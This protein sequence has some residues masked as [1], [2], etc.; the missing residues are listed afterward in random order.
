M[1]YGIWEYDSN[2]GLIGRPE[3]LPEIYVSKQRIWETENLEVG[4]VW[5][6]P[7][8]FAKS[9][10]FT[11]AIATDFNKAFYFAMNDI[12]GQRPES[13]HMPFDLDAR[14]LSHQLQILNNI[15]PGPNE[16]ILA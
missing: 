14:T 10:W 16:E 12:E 9:S 3:N 1:K 4:T 5:K 13:T 11:P 15:F 2:F 6:W 8:F 7:V